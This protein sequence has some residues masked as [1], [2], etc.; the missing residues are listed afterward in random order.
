MQATTSG[1]IAGLLAG[2]ATA[3]FFYLNPELSPFEMHEGVLGLIV[4]VPTLI[5]VSLM[6]PRQ[7]QD[8]LK[9]FFQ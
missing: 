7:D 2:L 5:A 3:L 1:A 6:T 9:G 8:H 4:H